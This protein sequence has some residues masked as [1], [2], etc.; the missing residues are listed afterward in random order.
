MAG[1]DSTGF[2]Q[3]T[4]TEIIESLKAGYRGVYGA[5]VNIAAR[6]RI[7]QR[8]AL[9]ANELSEVW[10]LGE[11]LF[12]AMDP[13]S[14]TGA[15]LDNQLKLVGIERQPAT[16]STVV[17]TLVGG[18]TTVIAAGKRASV[19]DTEAT[20]AI[21]A[22]AT[23]ALATAWAP[24]TSYSLGQRVRNVGNVYQCTKAGLSFAG[25]TGTSLSI[26]DGTVIWRYLGVGTGAVD[27]AATATVTGPVQGFAETIAVIDTPVSGW[28]NVVNLLDAETGNDVEQDADARARRDLSFSKQ[29]LSPLDAIRAEVLAVDGVTSC[30]IFE[31]FTDATVDGVPMKSFETLVEGGVDQ[32]II[33]AIFRKRPGGIQAY[34]NTSG[35]AVDS[36]GGNHTIA[37]SR[38]VDV[39]IWVAVTQTYDP[40]LYP[41]NGDVQTQDAL[42]ERQNAKAV[43][44]DVV[45]SAIAAGMFLDVPGLYDV[46]QVLIGTVN[47]PVSTATV[48]I[49]PRQKAKFDTSRVSVTSS[50]GSV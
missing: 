43:G 38:P 47:P 19:A 7:G 6:S 46:S 22:G 36:A 9:F 3:K 5:S 10:E 12:N 20:F 17:L 31:N 13:A 49:T 2:T 50:V 23:I 37:F 26:V 1:V 8:M 48:A 39:D 44:R 11:A 15:G 18:A 32:S 27:A 4:V 42:V 24:I 28:N 14:A 16:F 21:D 45:S 40:L 34:G 29:A 35:T 30:T 41:S 33:N 25:P